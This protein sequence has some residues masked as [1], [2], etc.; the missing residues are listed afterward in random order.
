MEKYIV[1][2]EDLIGEIEDF[3]IE[4]VQ[5]MVDYQVE[6]GNQADVT[7]FQNKIDMNDVHKGFWW[8][9]TSEGYYF[10]RDVI[11]YKGFHVFF[12]KYPK[13]FIPKK[14]ERVL[15]S[16]N[17]D[18]WSEKIFFCYME[19]CIL[20]YITVS[21]AYEDRYL[22]GEKIALV[23]WQY[24]KPLEPTVKEL[25]LQEIAEKFGVDEV[26]IIDK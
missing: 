19:E 12:E 21:D 26:K 20:P 7:V 15:V 1:K 18:N 17:E 2:Q 10:W 3:P 22:K 25:T 14:G 13:V 6:H 11:Q 23:S 4:V 5:K 24:C 8:S 9:K 16:D